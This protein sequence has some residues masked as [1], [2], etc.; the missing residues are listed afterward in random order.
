MATAAHVLAVCENAH[1]HRP[2]HEDRPSGGIPELASLGC[3]LGSW[4]PEV[5]CVATCLKIVRG[6]AYKRLLT[7]DDSSAEPG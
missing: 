5:D 4:L 2:A 7:K 6:G 1:L 3:L